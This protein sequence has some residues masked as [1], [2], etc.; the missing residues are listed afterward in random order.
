MAISGEALSRAL[1]FVMFA[2]AAKEDATPDQRDRL[3]KVIPPLLDHY[4]AGRIQEDDV[5]R[6]IRKIM[7]QDW[8]PGPK[9]RQG[10]WSEHIDG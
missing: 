1:A 10:A 7:G 2:G 9:W 3:R 4:K 8:R 5:R 6:A